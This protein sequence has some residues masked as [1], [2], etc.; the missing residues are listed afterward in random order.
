MAEVII[1]LIFNYCANKIISLKKIFAN[2]LWKYVIATVVM[3]FFTYELRNYLPDFPLL[4]RLILII[5][6]AVAVYFSILA[7]VKEQNASSTLNK[8]LQKGIHWKTVHAI[9]IGTLAAKIP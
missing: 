2:I 7:V 5:V 6:L 4:I 3:G 1:F 8:I 9:D